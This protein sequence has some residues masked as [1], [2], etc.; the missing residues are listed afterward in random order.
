MAMGTNWTSR[1]A[2]A[3]AAL[4]RGRRRDADARRNTGE[5]DR[6]TVRYREHG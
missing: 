4:F 6:V 3:R 5:L 1:L 2:E